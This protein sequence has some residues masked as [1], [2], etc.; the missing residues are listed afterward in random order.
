MYPFICFCYRAQGLYRVSFCKHGK[1]MQRHD[2][3]MKRMPWTPPYNSA[4]ISTCVFFFFL[5]SL[6][7]STLTLMRC[8]V[9]LPLAAGSPSHLQHTRKHTCPY[10]SN[11]N[12]HIHTLS[13]IKKNNMRETSSLAC[14]NNAYYLVLLVLSDIVAGNRH[15]SFKI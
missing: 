1:S 12:T 7:F 2:D 15:I 10:C 13:T 5:F 4:L 14:F 6:S 9:T 11:T 3:S 8:F